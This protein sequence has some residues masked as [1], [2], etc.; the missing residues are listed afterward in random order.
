MN[1]DEIKHYMNGV[2][3]LAEPGINAGPKTACG[4]EGP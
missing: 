4:G 3:P 1:R 2:A